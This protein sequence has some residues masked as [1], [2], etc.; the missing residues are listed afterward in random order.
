MKKF[1]NSWLSVTTIIISFLYIYCF[2]LCLKAYWTNLIVPLNFRD[3][4]SSW[5]KEWWPRWCVYLLFL[6]LGVNSFLNSLLDFQFSY[7]NP[8]LRE[9]NPSCCKFLPVPCWRHCLKTITIEN[10]RASTNEETLKADEETLEK[11]FYEN[12]KILESF[13][14]HP[15]ADS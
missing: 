9:E 12:A 1:L 15:R 7:K 3:C 2:I 4:F 6:L 14:F 11:Y 13:E 10:F 8:I 5:F